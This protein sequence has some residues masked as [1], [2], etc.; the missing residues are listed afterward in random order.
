MGSSNLSS[1]PTQLIHPL[2]S[3]IPVDLFVSKKRLSLN[4]KF[5]DACGNLVF[6]VDD[7]HYSVYSNSGRDTGGGWEGFGS[8]GQLIFKV[9]KKFVSKW[10]GEIELEVFPVSNG[11][12]AAAKDA[13]DVIKVKGS[14][15][16]RSCTIYRGNSIMA[17]TSLLYK[18]GKLT[19]GRRKFR[20]TM[21]PGLV[22]QALIVALIVIFFD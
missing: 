11:V 12:A 6:R 15:F 3:P 8:E 13:E 16:H 4:L 10:K 2:T 20:V 14:P 9:E 7:N 22:D 5:N 18:L 1:S 19:T 21:F 17:Q